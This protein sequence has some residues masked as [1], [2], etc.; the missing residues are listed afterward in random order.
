MKIN[1]DNLKLALDIASAVADE[2]F[3]LF[4]KDKVELQTLSDDTSMFVQYEYAEEHGIEKPLFVNYQDLKKALARLNEINLETEG[5]LKLTD[6][7]KKFEFPLIQPKEEQR[8]RIYPVLPRDTNMDLQ[9]EPFFAS[10]KDAL[11]CA[12]AVRLS[13]TEPGLFLKTYDSQKK[14][15]NVIDGVN[16]VVGE[17]IS[18][19][20]AL[21]Y[22]EKAEQGKK[23]SEEFDI[24]FGKDTPLGL[25]FNG[26][27]KQ[28][29]YMIANRVVN[30]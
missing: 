5:T 26:E 25:H 16:V 19:C 15:S 8:I 22:L 4:K 10:V 9:S 7:Q 18:T 13:G 17:G 3:L 23:I 11:T 27:G 2:G 21:D 12:E 30:D 1:K 20:I 14:Y 24:S 28:L 29:R 6:G